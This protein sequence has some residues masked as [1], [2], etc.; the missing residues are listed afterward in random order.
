M[1]FVQ[2]LFFNFLQLDIIMTTYCQIF[3]LSKLA[4]GFHSFGNPLVYDSSLQFA[5]WHEIYGLQ[6]LVTVRFEPTIYPDFAN[7]RFCMPEILPQPANY[8]KPDKTDN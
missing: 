4:V 5:K 6:N 8:G 3:L 2:S 1:T 7:F